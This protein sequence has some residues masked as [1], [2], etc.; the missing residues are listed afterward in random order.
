MENV[1]L[2]TTDQVFTGIAGAFAVLPLFASYSV[3]TDSS[4]RDYVAI[5]GGAIAVPCAL[6]AALLA[7][8]YRGGTLR[9]GLAFGALVLGGFQLARGLGVFADTGGRT[10]VA[11][12]EISPPPEPEQAPPEPESVQ[13]ER[14]C[15]A[16]KPDAAACT[17][18]GVM[19]LQGH[20]VAKDEKRGLELFRRACELGDAVGCRN[21]GVLYRDGVGV[22]VDLA[23]ALTF[24]DKSCGLQDYS[25]C[26]SAGLAYIQGFGTKKDAARG[27]K[28]LA[29]ACDQKEASGCFDLGVATEAGDGTRKD[30]KRARE[31]YRQA[32]DGDD[33]AGCNNYA[34]MVLRGEGGPKDRAQAIEMFRKACS[35]HN[36]N[37]CATLKK[38][39]SE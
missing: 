28:L 39:K 12:R 19:V 25:G 17:N 35:L 32:C 13:L 6:V 33:D 30:P 23:Q 5:A 26:H 9:I 3:T 14:A 11:I 10:E 4:Y 34:V 2:R 21:V 8:K 27:A 7:I 15:N 29:T 36:D 24:F 1:S 20:G 16:G 31:L 38:L 22:T 18:F 37:S